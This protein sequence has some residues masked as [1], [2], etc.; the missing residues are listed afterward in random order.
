M[1]WG[2]F[3]EREE[4]RKSPGRIL[5]DRKPWDGT[6]QID[7]PTWAPTYKEKAKSDRPAGRCLPELPPGPGS[8][9]T[10]PNGNR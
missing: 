6:R 9:T 4:K 3:L 2:P 10:T 8:T 5:R 1:I 7:R